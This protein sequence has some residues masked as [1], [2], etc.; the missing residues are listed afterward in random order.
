MPFILQESPLQQPP[1]FL[2]AD[3]S[4]LQHEPSFPSLI[5]Q[6]SPLQQ[7]HAIAQH[8]CA[9]L[10]GSFCV[11]FCA[12]AILDRAKARPSMTPMVNPLML[13]I[14]VSP[15]RRDKPAGCIE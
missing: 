5:G 7:H 4:P 9:F 11:A 3:L 13:F 14:F 8:D 15:V 2:A 10:L 6:E 12:K 1:S